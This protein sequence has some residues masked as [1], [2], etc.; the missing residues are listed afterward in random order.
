MYAP[1]HTVHLCGGRQSGKCGFAT[2]FASAAAAGA[3]YPPSGKNFRIP[4]KAMPAIVV[5]ALMGC[6]ITPLLLY[7]SYRH[8]ATGTA[9]V[10]H[11]VYP[12]VVVLIGLMFLRK[13]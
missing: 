5:I 7:G 12:A 8:I 10:F 1:H 9:T 6:C 4:V 3:A 11:F 13:K 2:E